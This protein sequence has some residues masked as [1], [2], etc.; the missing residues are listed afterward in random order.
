MSTYLVVAH[1]SDQG[2]A[3]TALRQLLRSLRALGHEP[4]VLLPAG[5]GA[6]VDWCR[7]ERIEGLVLPM[8]QTLPTAP[9]AFLQVSLQGLEAM[10]AQLVPRGFAGV[11]TNSAVMVHGARFAE[12]LGV[13]HLTWIHEL[14]DDDS[15]VRSRGIPS[16]AYLRIVGN[17][18]DHLLCCSAAVQAH[19]LAAGV[20]TPSSVLYPFT[21]DAGAP[22][23][24]VKDHNGRITLMAIGVQSIRKNPVFAVTVLQALR[25]RGHDAQLHIVGES[26]TQT[27]RLQAA[28][29]RRGLAGVV[30][31][32]G[33]V[34]DPY[35]LAG[36]RVINLIGASSEA[37]G[38][39]VPE[40]LLRGIPVVASRSG[41]PQEMLAAEDLF[42][43][44]DLATCVHIV[45]RMAAN[46]ARESERARQRYAE[47][48]PQY[49]AE[50]QSRVLAE[51]LAQAGVRRRG[52][53]RAPNPYFGP[54]LRDAVQLAGLPRE[55]LVEN[56]A[57]VAGLPVAEIEQRIAL[58]VRQ[59]GHAVMADCRSFD[60]VPFSASPH[61]DDLY[62]DGAGF[63]IELASTYADQGRLLMSAFILARL[64]HESSARP[65]RT[66]ALG[67]GI[68]VD[69][70]RLA[71]MGLDV[72]Y[73]DF[74][75]SMTARVARRNFETHAQAAATGT[76]Q[77]RVIADAAQQPPYDAVVCLEVI[78]HVS[79][80]LGFLRMLS[81][82]LVPGGLLFISECFDGVRDHWPT[83]LQS[84]EDFSG[85][86][87]LMAGQFGLALDD[88][89]TGPFAKPYVFRKC[90]PGEAVNVGALFRADK[91]LLRNSFGAQMQVGG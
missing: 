67:D 30:H 39:T 45:E 5:Q 81:E 59:P 17:T 20:D 55:R 49:S 68:G 34:S 60:V 83:H 70:L 2:G 86:L 76:G 78:E 14:V 42:D 56:V 37:F 54:R 85:L 44:G 61:S 65:L 40:S 19:L 36:G 15:E 3:Q 57:Q 46:Y 11:I 63:A 62:R 23:A 21:E 18:S 53:A 43:I 77:I 35:A 41:G 52:V 6:M 64:V 89:N 26:S 87:P 91:G 31:V 50:H 12:L 33:N 74:D 79:D 8:M 73:I 29:Q 84:N 4:T 58:D 25:L 71:G 1:S 32:H 7:Q 66:L 47:L 82:R 69:S 48:R 22:P 88:Y 51:A 24:A 16:A 9:A 10:A 27:P 28:I 75:A 90:A 72:D 38:L 80:P 13:P